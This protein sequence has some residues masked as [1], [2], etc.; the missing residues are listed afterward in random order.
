MSDY[1]KAENCEKGGQR[2]VVFVEPPRGVMT[3][4][5]ERRTFLN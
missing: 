5:E 3:L 2:E 1:D 4:S